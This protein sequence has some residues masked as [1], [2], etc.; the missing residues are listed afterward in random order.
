MKFIESQRSNSLQ[1]EYT[2]GLRIMVRM[3]LPDEIREFFKKQGAVGGKTRAENLTAEQRSEAA[4][5]A[6]QSRWA[7]SKKVSKKKRSKNVRGDK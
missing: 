2:K 6:V 1:L 3:K 7:K 4:R 5:K